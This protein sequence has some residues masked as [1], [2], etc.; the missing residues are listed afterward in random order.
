ML[1]SFGET[2]ENLNVL[3]PHNFEELAKGFRY[4]GYFLKAD[5][6]KTVDWRWLLTK[7]EERIGLWCNRWLSIGG[8]YT[9]VKSVLEGQPGW[10]WWLYL[11]PF[12]KKYR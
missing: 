10:L 3:F 8:Q 12:C 2:L 9:L 11:L 6:Y 5:A 1:E 7:I 4:L